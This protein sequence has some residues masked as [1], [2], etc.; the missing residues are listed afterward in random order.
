MLENIIK[1]VITE[2]KLFN[3]SNFFDHDLQ[4]V[5]EIIL[6]MFF[7]VYYNYCGFIW[8]F[9]DLICWIL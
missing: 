2:I 9:N 1:V 4:I 7:D 8:S 5:L 6:K 3:S